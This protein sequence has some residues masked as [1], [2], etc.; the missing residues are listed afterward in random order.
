MKLRIAILG[1]R[2]IPNQYGGF[3]QVAAYL[4]QGLVKKG[5]E[6]T[7]YNSHKHPYQKN[8][9]NCVHI[10]H[11]FDPEYFLGTAGQFIYDL[12]CIFHARKQKYDII[13]ALGY[14]SSSIW[15]RAYPKTA[16]TITN[17]DGL[18]WK[19]SKYSGM[20]KKFLSHAEKLAVQYSD[21]L[22]ADSPAVQD[23]LEKKYSIKSN[24]IA[25]GAEIIT[26]EDDKV[27]ATYGVEKNEYFMLMA[28]MEPEN[29]IETIL[30]GITGKTLVIGSAGNAYGKRLKKK[31]GDDDRIQFIGAVYDPVALHTLKKYCRMYFHGHSVGGTNPSLLEAMASKALI[32]AHDNPF[33]RVVTGSDALYFTNAGDVAQACQQMPANATEM[34]NRNFE[35]V[36]TDFGWEKII[37]QYESLF[38]ECYK[39]SK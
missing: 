13:L 37:S 16:V 17:M 9:W 30:D 23:Y 21:H 5:H 31:Y 24:Y 6:V 4:S 12:N 27:F 34:I 10:V 22:V 15:G 19:R 2:G 29:N 18:E 25:Y 20:V 38:L 7:V 33:N 1:T 14:T 3:E 39:K 35:K 32:C 36:S 26:T 28:R 11:C 8:N